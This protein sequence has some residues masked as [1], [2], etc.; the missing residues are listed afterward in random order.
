MATDVSIQAVSPELGEQFV[1]VLASQDGGAAAA[2]AA[3]GA[4]A[5][6]SAIAEWKLGKLSKIARRIA[7]AR[8]NSPA[9]EN[10]LKVMVSLLSVFIE[11]RGY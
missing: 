2:A 1:S 3:A 10:R 6:V 11:V 9:R 7:P 8:A 5:A 4:S